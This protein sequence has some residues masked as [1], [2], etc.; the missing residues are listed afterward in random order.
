MKIIDCGDGSAAV[1]DNFLLAQ[2]LGGPKSGTI[3]AVALPTLLQRQIYALSNAPAP[4]SGSGE[5][6]LLTYVQPQ[7]RTNYHANTPNPSVFYV[8]AIWEPYE[9]GDIIFAFQPAGDGTGVTV[10]LVQPAHW[11]VGTTVALGSVVTWQDINVDGRIWRTETQLCD[12]NYVLAAMTPEYSDSLLTNPI[13][14]G[15]H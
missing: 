5:G 4:D 6:G 13:L 2:F 14:W 9:R 7:I 8:E 10:P 11:A 12:G 3:V 1:Y 15:S